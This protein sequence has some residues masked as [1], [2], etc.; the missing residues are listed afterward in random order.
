MKKKI[1]L[2]LLCLLLVI[3][4]FSAWRKS[5]AATVYDT[6]VGVQTAFTA[7]YPSSVTT[8][9]GLSVTG[10][11]SRPSSS[12][13]V[14]VLS[15]T[16]YMSATNA[17]ESVYSKSATRTDPSPTTGASTYTGYYPDWSL[18]ATGAAS[19][20]I[21]V[22]LTKAVA[23]TKEYGT[24]TCNLTA[25]LATI[26][27]TAPVST[28]GG[29]SG[30]GSSG[31]GGSGGGSSSGGTSTGG[32]SSGSNTTTTSTTSSGTS[33]SPKLST[34]TNIPPKTITTASGEQIQVFPVIV[35]VKD[36]NNQAVKGAKVTIEGQTD[37]TDTE[38]GAL[39]QDIPEG[40]HTLT[41]VYK[42][43]KTQQ[44]FTV[45]AGDKVNTVN[46]TI[47]KVTIFQKL[48]LPGAI[49]AAVIVAGGTVTFLVIR[50]RSK[51]AGFQPGP[52][53]TSFG[54]APVFTGDM[55]TVQSPVIN[56]PPPNQ[57]IMPA[58]PTTVIPTLA[59]TPN[60]GQYPAPGQNVVGLPG[61]VVS[62]TV[63]TPTAANMPLS[64]ISKFSN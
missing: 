17:S 61:T 7:T 24:I 6:C 11:T 27:I 35:I 8:G 58:Q 37:E 53:Q 13:G 54:A 56:T 25:T 57:P 40:N 10:I 28:G 51:F 42:D 36:K 23:Q 34:A 63:T 59:V 41:V 64:N 26:N 12:Y 5:Y 21:V 16:L 31:G 33:T 48:L 1:A 55:S 20:Q 3:G 32:T 30:G 60:V 29:G 22:K 62:P 45:T 44:S 49:G 46:V 4:L 38:G 47:A 2:G 14:T 19:S 39:F 52:G 18:T 9:T 50:K 43:L 15:A